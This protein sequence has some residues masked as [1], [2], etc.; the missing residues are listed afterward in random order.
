MKY[1]AFISYS[2]SDKAWAN[3][4]HRKVETYRI[5]ALLRKEHKELPERFY[6]VFRDREELAGASVLGDR[7]REALRESRW[8]IV[9]CSPRSALSPWVNEEIYYFKQLGRANQILCFV[10]DGVPNVT[11]AD[12]DVGSAEE[13][14]PPSILHPVGKAG[15][16]DIEAWEEPLA[17]DARPCA[18]GKQAAFLK[19]IAGMAGIGFGDLVRRDQQRAIRK[20]RWMVSGVS[21]LVLAFAGLG[22][23]L[24]FQK[25]EAIRQRDM[26]REVRDGAQ[27]VNTFIIVDLRSKLRDLGRLDLLEDVT[28]K[29]LDYHEKLPEELADDPSVLRARAI[30]MDY[31]GQQAMSR[32]DSEGAV[33]LL[34]KS[35]EAWQSLV[36]RG[37]SGD[38]A[39]VGSVVSS[40]ILADVLARAGDKAGA[41]AVCDEGLFRLSKWADREVL[42]QRRSAVLFAMLLSEKGDV[43]RRMGRKT[44]ALAVLDEAARL[45]KESVEDGSKNSNRGQ[46]AVMCFTQLAMVYREENK[47][48]AALEQALF[49]VEA[50]EHYA[51]FDMGNA[52]GWM[53]VI[54][55]ESELCA[56]HL[57]MKNWA[58]AEAVAQDRLQW[59]A[60]LRG[61]DPVNP[62]YMGM[63]AAAR[64]DLGTALGKQQKIEPAVEEFQRGINLLADLVQRYPTDTRWREDL[65]IVFRRRG[66]LAF[67]CEVWDV[68]LE[69]YGSSLRMR[70]SLITIAPTD[71]RLHIQ[72]AGVVLAQAEVLQKT[73][74]IDGALAALDEAERRLGIVPA[75]GKNQIFNAVSSGIGEARKA[76]MG[77]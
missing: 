63:E 70:D 56:V 10:V 2:H 33:Q 15:E 11:A 37:D 18:D 68:A 28:A 19:I 64:D 25:K 52:G 13:C 34:K 22:G 42:D 51:E 26:A 31:A 77:E 62:A 16:L 23:A 48:P 61:R 47:M 76:W 53:S 69:D 36:E 14:F 6:P 39:L 46:N 8:L 71:A 40:R 43:L 32:G 57:E 41:L 58:E 38:E 55:S 3:W 49:A 72:A 4:L 75:T 29:V 65:A 50:A 35:Q 60:R 7:L 24:Y 17:A 5:P 73:G 30:A 9:V 67:D 59:I 44:D 45:A 66:D 74:D 54:S 20:L 1:H 21:A 12:R 27:E